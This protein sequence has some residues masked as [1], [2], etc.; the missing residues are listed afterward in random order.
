MQISSECF[1]NLKKY[2][3]KFNPS[4]M[5]RISENNFGGVDKL[6]SIPLYAVYCIKEVKM[7]EKS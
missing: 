5:I 6:I 2:A 3:E 7:I 1:S 4:K